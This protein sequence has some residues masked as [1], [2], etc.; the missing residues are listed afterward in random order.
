[1]KETDTT[2]YTQSTELFRKLQQEA[3]Q[4][5]GKKEGPQPAKRRNKTT[6]PANTFKL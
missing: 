2:N 5:V 1:M 4:A 3:D 6:K